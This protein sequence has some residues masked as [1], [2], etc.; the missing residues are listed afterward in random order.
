M[1]S[2]QSRVERSLSRLRTDG[3][4]TEWRSFPAIGFF[5]LWTKEGR[6]PLTLTV[7]ET[8][9]FIRGARAALFGNVERSVGDRSGHV[10]SGGH[11]TPRIGRAGE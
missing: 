4:V 1:S 2:G 8:E 6:A 9:V 3:V 11:S 7:Q 5:A 10:E